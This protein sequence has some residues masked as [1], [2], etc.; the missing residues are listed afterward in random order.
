LDTS[1]LK[2]PLLYSAAFANFLQAVVYFIP[3]IYLPSYASDID[4]PPIQ[5]TLVV[6]LLNLALI[7][8]QVGMGGLSDRIGPDVPPIISSA[9]GAASVAILWGL[10]KN[11]ALL[12]VF[13]LIYGASAGGYSALWIKFAMEVTS[14]PYTQLA[15]WG[16]FSFER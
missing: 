4:I 7:F 8:G 9:V 16:F 11:F 10:S 12:S 1:V 15:V 14:D 6:S 2:K 5:S 3:G 13:S